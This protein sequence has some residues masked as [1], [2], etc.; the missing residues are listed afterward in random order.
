LILSLDHLPPKFHDWRV[1]V[2]PRHPSYNPFL[3]RSQRLQSSASF[4]EG[5][6]SVEFSGDLPSHLD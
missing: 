2:G 4:Y 1:L 6:F 3:T 5:E